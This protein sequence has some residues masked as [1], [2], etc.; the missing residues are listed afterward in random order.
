L[1]ELPIGMRLY[2]NRLPGSLG[3]E[4][5]QDYLYQLGLDFP[6]ENI[7]VKSYPR[8]VSGAMVVVPTAIVALLVNWAIN[9]QKLQGAEVVAEP[10]LNDTT[11]NPRYRFSAP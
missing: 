7:S 6:I 11:S 9:G 2:F 8:G 4:A 10:L 3:E 1:R 5:F